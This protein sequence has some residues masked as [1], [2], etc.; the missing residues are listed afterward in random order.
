MEPEELAAL[1]K[2]LIAR[3]DELRK[4]GDIEIE[5]VV[6]DPAEKV[7]EDAAPLTE[8]NQVIASRRNKNRAQELERIEVALRRLDADPDEFG[9]CEGCGN[10]IPIRRLEIMP[11]ARHCVACEEARAPRRGGRRRHL[12][13]YL[14]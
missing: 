9:Y 11:W 1:R 6:K 10:E 4:E 2:V 7:D 13:D 5:P 8:M 3:R 12:G 14:E